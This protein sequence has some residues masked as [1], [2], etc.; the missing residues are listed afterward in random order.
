MYLQ[1]TYT[2]VSQ[3]TTPLGCW[4][5]YTNILKHNYVMSCHTCS[6]TLYKAHLSSSTT[7]PGSSESLLEQDEREGKQGHEHPVTGVSEHHREE[8]GEGDGGEGG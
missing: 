3:C 5:T 4:Y 2:N 8:E 1:C 7:R 6:I